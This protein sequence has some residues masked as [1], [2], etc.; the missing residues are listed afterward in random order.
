MQH[1]DLKHAQCSPARPAHSLL[2]S[3]YLSCFV[4]IFRCGSYESAKPVDTAESQ[5]YPGVHFIKAFS[6]M[7]AQT[8]RRRRPALSCQQCRRRKIRCDHNNPCAN[9]LRHK[10]QCAYTLYVHSTGDKPRA[11]NGSGQPKRAFLGTVP[12]SS[13]L[14]GPRG[15]A[16]ITG[17]EAGLSPQGTSAQQPTPYATGSTYSQNRSITD[18]GPVDRSH[19]EP[20]QL[21]IGAAIPAGHMHSSHAPVQTPVGGTDGRDM[22]SFSEDTRGTE[23]DYSVAELL[24]RIRK[25]EESSGFHV[26]ARSSDWPP[27][28]VL[29]KSR[30]LGKKGKWM[31]VAREFSVI[32]ACYGEMTGRDSKNSLFKTPEIA[33]LVAQSG[34]FVKKCKNTARNIKLSRPRKSPSLPLEIGFPARDVADAMVNLYFASFESTHRVLHGPTFRAEYQQY[35]DSPESASIEL[36]LKILMVSGIGSSLHDHGNTGNALNNADLVHQW[37]RAAQNWLSGPLE[38]DRLSINGLQLYC[39]TILAR[40]M[41]SV[42]GDLIWISTGSLVQRAMQMGLNRDPKY[43][44]AMTPLQAELRRRLWATILELV[45]QSSLDSWMPPRISFDEFDTEPPSNIND[46]DLDQSTTVIQPHPMS[47]STQTSIQLALLETLPVRLGIVQYLNNLHS[48]PSYP[49]V[50]ELSR[51]LTKAIQ[52]CASTTKQDS[53]HCTPFRRNLLDYLLRRFAIPLHMSF[54][55]Q[56]RAEPSYHHSLRA[57]LDAAVAIISPGPDAPFARLMA[58]G[59]GMFRE[60]LRC[61][62]TAVALELLAHV[63]AQRLDGTLGRARAYRDMLKAA[64]RDLVALSERRIRLGETNVKSHMFLTMILAQVEAVEAGVLVELEVARSARDS[65]EFCHGILRE[66]MG[67]IPSAVPSPADAGPAT[68][69]ADGFQGHENYNMYGMGVEFDWD[70][71]MSDVG[72]S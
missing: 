21:R 60:G 5:D 33:S 15:Q 63:E 4:V 25:L 69:M 18:H 57:S 58:G 36:R 45:V 27:Q 17:A 31:G 2:Y 11:A 47:T 70:L 43:L 46:G 66:R 44:P 10:T 30:D 71:I 62:L 16:I 23:Q 34:E 51:E 39:L 50:L 12:S 48:E 8:R 56:S 29:N 54:S 32:I 41:F 9:C 49:R 28:L 40:Q 19:G 26:E 64:V 55:S 24:E 14:D 65:L 1:E 42:G 38:K 22:P 53:E 52:A 67:D 35:W 20:C 72:F 7:E 61:A 6:P 68:T 3:G 13:F 37:I 59:G